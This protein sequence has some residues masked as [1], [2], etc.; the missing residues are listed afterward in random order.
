MRTLRLVRVPDGITYTGPREWTIPLHVDWV[1]GA[2]LPNAVLPAYKTDDP[3]TGY[4][5]EIQIDRVP[6]PFS[7]LALATGLGA[8]GLR[9]R[10]R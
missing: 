10:R 1:T 4:Q 8:L 2:F 5:F 3:W 7:L 6:E 9:R